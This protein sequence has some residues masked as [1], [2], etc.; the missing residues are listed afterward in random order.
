MRMRK[1]KSEYK[2]IAHIRV[3]FLTGRQRSG[4]FAT[5]KQ[6]ENSEIHQRMRRRIN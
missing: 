1:Q 6:I 5:D 3:E 4:S 2:V